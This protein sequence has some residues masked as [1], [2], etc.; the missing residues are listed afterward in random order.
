MEE[1]MDVS[2]WEKEMTEGRGEKEIISFSSRP[3]A[4]SLDERK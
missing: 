2:W 4:I 1:E 3:S